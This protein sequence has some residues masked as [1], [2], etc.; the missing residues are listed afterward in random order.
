MSSNPILSCTG[1]SSIRGGCSAANPMSIVASLEIINFSDFMTGLRCQPKVRG[2]DTADP[3]CG[4]VDTSNVFRLESLLG[5]S[6]ELD[7]QFCLLGEHAGDYCDVAVATIT[8]DVDQ[9]DCQEQC[10]TLMLSQKIKTCG[11][12][13]ITPLISM[14]DMIAGKEVALNLICDTCSDFARKC[15]PLPSCANATSTTTIREYKCTDSEDA[16]C[17]CAC[18]TKN[19]PPKFITSTH[20]KFDF[21]VKDVLNACCLQISAVDCKTGNVLGCSKIVNISK[22]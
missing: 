3:N 7:N 12:Q 11:Q 15:N 14:S 2:C 4:G 5:F 10:Y 9:L 6:P 16:G 20:Y 21:V 1:C 13:E 22:D 17:C 18:D 19:V 8:V